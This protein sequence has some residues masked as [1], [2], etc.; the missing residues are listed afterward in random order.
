MY[1]INLN[2][3]IPGL[4]RKSRDST[5][6][7]IVSGSRDPGIKNATFRIQTNRFNKSNPHTA[8]QVS[9]AKL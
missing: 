9:E 3:G 1:A 8:T 7:E 6:S 5:P 4:K 2:T